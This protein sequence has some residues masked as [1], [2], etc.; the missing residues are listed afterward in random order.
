MPDLEFKI[1]ER[2][3]ESGDPV[4]EFFLFFLTDV[5]SLVVEEHQIDVA[6]GAEFGSTET[7]VSNEDDFGRLSAVFGGRNILWRAGNGLPHMNDECLFDGGVGFTNE[8]PT[9][10]GAVVHAEAVEFHL[11]EPSVARQFLIGLAERRQRKA[12]PGIF[13]DLGDERIHRAGGC[14]SQWENQSGI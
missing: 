2:V 9:G 5:Y 14:V 13:P 3:E 8:T 6:K 10:S 4:G 12:L 11:E 1:P 7:T